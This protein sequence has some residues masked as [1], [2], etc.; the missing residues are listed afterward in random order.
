MPDFERDR[1]RVL[2]ETLQA[3]VPKIESRRRTA[4]YRIATL[5]GLAPTAFDPHLLTCHAPLHL[6][7]VLPVGDG[8][9][10]LRRRPDVRGAERRLAAATARIGVATA[11]LYP[12][13]RLGLTAGSTGAATDMLSPLTNRF[14]AGP[15]ISWNMHQSA[16]RAK[17]DATKAQ[18]R[19]DLA[20]FDGT[21]LKALREVETALDKYAADLDGFKSLEASRDDAAVVAARTQMLRRGG[22]VNELAALDAERASI[23]AEDAV[24]GAE[25]EINT[26][27]IALFL[28]LGGGWG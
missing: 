17:I 11:A 19:A 21:V 22:K 18:T 8:Q 3:R 5:Q 2:L 6:P 14:A 13:I 10:L 25:A 24:A 15:L 1:Q 9:A 28:A 7:Q 4:G 23:S 12:D 26:D 20:D 16:V 27:Q